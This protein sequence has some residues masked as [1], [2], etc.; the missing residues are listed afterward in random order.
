MNPWHCDLFLETIDL[1][2]SSQ[3]PIKIQQCEMG[4]LFRAEDFVTLQWK[5]QRFPRGESEEQIFSN[6]I[7]CFEYFSTCKSCSNFI[8]KSVCIGSNVICITNTLSMKCQRSSESCALK[9][10][11]P[12]WRELFPPSMVVYGMVW[13]KHHLQ[14]AE[15][16]R[17]WSQTHCFLSRHTYLPSFVFLI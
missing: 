5:S 1:T 10:C 13:Y 4:W 17:R 6:S 14:E 3:H 15:R 16:K 9:S 12:S 8:Q 2:Q 11:D 7:F